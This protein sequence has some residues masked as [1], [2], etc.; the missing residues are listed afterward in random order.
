MSYGKGMLCI[1]GSTSGLLR[2]LRQ[3]IKPCCVGFLITAWFLTTWPPALAEPGELA[4]EAI[5]L[6][7]GISGSSPLGEEQQTDFQQADV[8]GII[9]LP[10]E[11]DIGW[12]WTLGT[13]MVG[14]AGILRGAKE[15]NA[16]MTVVPLNVVLGRK[17]GWLSID[18]GGG[19]ALL[20]GYTFGKQN[21]GGPFQFVWTF[22]A[23]SRVAGP[24]GIAYHFQ[25]Y[26]DATLY[27]SDSRGVDLH[28]FELVYWF[29]EG[30][31]GS[32]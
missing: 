14:S 27:G 23:S 9:R 26:S 2:T 10:W 5:S 31:T 12:G 11:T 1:A 20:S 13:R 18:M 30:T 15:S 4:L 21:F 25:H 3:S 19:G 17:D 16:I 8:A 29:G 24:F 32:R 7:G 22:G 6:R 28:L